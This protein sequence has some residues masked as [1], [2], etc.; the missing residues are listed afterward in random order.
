MEKTQQMEEFSS[1][2]WI[3]MLRVPRPL[4]LGPT[5]RT[6]R[7]SVSMSVHF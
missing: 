4:R 6:A 1:T 5:C 2:W 7:S 3:L